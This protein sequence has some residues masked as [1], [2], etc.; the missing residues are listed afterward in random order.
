MTYD[1]IIA[2]SGPAGLSAA[3]YASR[4]GFKYAVIEKMFMGIGQ[5]SEADKIDNYLGFESINGF[6]LGMK[7]RSQAEKCGTKF[8]SGEIVK[9]E[10]A[11]NLFNIHLKNSSEKIISK[12]IIYA[13]GASHRKL[14]IKG[15]S[16][17]TGKGVSYCAV[18]D[19]AFYKN[20]TAVV[21][22]GG[23]TALSEAVYLSNLAE[24][25][26]LMHR[27]EGF[28]ASENLQ[29]KIAEIKNIETI[30]NAV[31]IEINGDKKVS[32]I[33]FKQNEVIKKLFVDGVFVAVGMKPETDIIK[34]IV[35]TNESGYIISDET[36][37][38]SLDGFFA[39]GDVRTKSLRQI[40]TAVSDGANCVN[41]V[42]KYISKNQ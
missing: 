3:V 11:D 1:L 8:I 28:R 27:R 23:D 12:T 31:P 39:A 6:D 14:G 20:K 25:V 24:K 40:I 18:C 34:N 9:I 21:V 32:S 41:S 26:Y 38:T 7:F 4:A 13:I 10:K 22:G 42:E 36:G 2:G 17:F 15:E 33:I 29:K 5:I 35:D 37:I 30:L 16:E 19:G